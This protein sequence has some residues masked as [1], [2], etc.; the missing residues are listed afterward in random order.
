VWH[1]TASWAAWHS[2]VTSQRCLVSFTRVP[3]MSSHV[4]NWLTVCPLW[5]PTRQ[6]LFLLNVVLPFIRIRIQ[7][8]LYIS[9]ILLHTIC[10]LHINR[11]NLLVILERVVATAQ[12]NWIRQMFSFGIYSLNLFLL[13]AIGVELGERNAL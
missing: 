5:A 1:F 6:L 7:V 10:S 13:L 12:F 3:G 4:V 11:F 2:W 9:I 8:V